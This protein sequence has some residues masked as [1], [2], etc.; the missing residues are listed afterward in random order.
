MKKTWF[1]F[2]ISFTLI[3]LL[4]VIAIIGVL[5]ALLL[6]AV[7]KVREA[8]NR[9]QC[10][11][12]L[13]QIGLA[14]HNF[15]D[16]YGYFPHSPDPMDWLGLNQQYWPPAGTSQGGFRTIPPTH[17]LA[18]SYM[19]DGTPHSPKLQTA[20]WAYQVLPFMEQSPLHDTSDVT[21]PPG[22]GPPWTNGLNV[23]ALN[24]PAFV[25][26]PVG[27]YATL[28]DT[29]FPGQV[30]TTPVKSY[31]CPSM[32]SPGLHTGLWAWGQTPP[33]VAFIDYAAAHGWNLAVP[34]WTYSN[35]QPWSDMG[36]SATTWWGNEGW[37]SVIECR[38][39]GKV[40]FASITDGSSNTILV[41]EKFV[42]PNC[43]NGN[44]GWEYDA[45]GLVGGS[46]MDDRRSTGI[47]T[48]NVP[49]GDFTLLGNPA[50]DKNVPFSSDPNSQD[51][52]SLFY[53]GSAHPA[54]MNAVFADGSVHNVKYGIDPQVFNA[55]GVRNDGTNLVG[56][57][58]DDF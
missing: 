47:E 18:V 8:A 55:L 50:L 51:W 38:R 2:R 28:A 40:T 36:G 52:R 49:G 30:M 23:I 7:Q 46:F 39:A 53:F 9:I 1:P 29:A 21:Y 56:Q 3:E 19:P 14:A 15:H 10:A 4:V 32:R 24:P 20:S 58:Q 54:G 42:Q 31:N 6:P 48:G 12:N 11:N 33:N 45:F 44:C 57:G 43:W 5:I 41:G 17:A 25:G 22:S 34:M 13:K 37:A 16:T 27:S 35:G 26:Y